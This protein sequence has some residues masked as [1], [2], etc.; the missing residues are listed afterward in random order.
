MANFE[1]HK[2]RLGDYIEMITEKSKGKNQYD[3]PICDSGTGKHH[4]GAFTFYPET[5][6]WYCFSCHRGGDIYD[7]IGLV[8]DIPDK[9]D[10]LKR[11]CEIFGD[12]VAMTKAPL[13]PKKPQ[14][15]EPNIS[16][17]EYVKE[18]AKHIK[19]TNYLQSRGISY[20][21]AEKMGIGFDKK[22]FSF[23]GIVFPT[24]NS[25]AMRNIDHTSKNRYLKQKG[26]SD[27]FNKVALSESDKPVY[28]VEGYMDALSI[29][30]AGGEAVALG[31]TGFSKLISIV[32]KHEPK[33]LLIVSMDDDDAGKTAQIKLLNELRC[34]NIPC[35]GFQPYNGSKDANEALQHDRKSFIEVVMYGESL[36]D[37]YF[38]TEKEK[39]FQNSTAVYLQSFINGISD[40]ANTPPIKTGFKNLDTVLDGGL[41]EGL[42]T[43]GAIS[44]LGKTTLAMQ[45]MDQI[46]Q[47]GHDVLIFS[48]EMARN[49]LISKSISRHT[50][51]NAM[52]NGIKTNNAK[53]SRGITDGSRYA[54]YNKIEI[55]LINQ[56]VISYSE[57]AKHIYIS[58]GIGNIGV[59]EIRQ[60]IGKHIRYTGN[61]PI[62]L[63]DYLQILAP[64]DV[65][66][67]DK[68]N[69]DK[70]I[71]ELKRISRDFKIPIIVIS[72][73][74]RQNYSESVR[75][76]AFK[77]SG[78][79]EYSSDV[80]IGLQLRGA[81]QKGFDEINEK[82]K[83]PRQVELVI[84]KNRDART[85]EKVAF[86]YY[87]VFNYFKEK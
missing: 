50:V 37:E 24:G 23:G 13:K 81:G 1:D 32:K 10:Q 44:S 35:V 3:C 43:I 29:I 42:H 57:Y 47:Q 26:E 40:S 53:S 86:E 59:D 18:C 20:D 58:E 12:S 46:A 68:Q 39:Y 75:M 71:T 19:E 61:T 15:Q 6:S 67:S 14:T 85:G 41:Y 16:I 34:L 84:L 77:E 5:N 51:I 74:N 33:R 30:E 63:V 55:E 83:D 54:N 62:V 78:I 76:E 28:I 73:F 45:I 49:Q 48:L 64:N 79:I 2:D 56:S 31:G 7:L 87:P 36:E 38:K 52:N 80:L 66:A 11:V 4:T 9:G 22:A 17:S 70:A 72:S 69:T 82:N 8:E 27:L 65:R 25:Y 60:T 21:T